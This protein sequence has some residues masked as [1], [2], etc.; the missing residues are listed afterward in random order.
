[1][2]EYA[3]KGYLVASKAISRSWLNRICVG[4]LFISLLVILLYISI[5]LAPIKHSL[6]L[7]HNIPDPIGIYAVI[8][9]IVSCVLRFW[10]PKDRE[11]IIG[12]TLYLLV[13][14]LALAINIASAEPIS[15]LI[16]I[17]LLVASFAGFFGSSMAITSSALL[18]I[19]IGFMWINNQ[20]T[21]PQAIQL[22]ILGISP[23]ILGLI[24]WH[25]DKTE[26]K[27]EDT[28]K[29]IVN[30]LGTTKSK[31]DIVISNIDD[32]VL[33]ISQ[34]GI[35]ELINPAA[36]KLLGW[37]QKDA[38]NL[39]WKSVLKIITSDG[40]DVADVDNPIAQALDIKTPVH[41]DRFQL[42]TA[43]EKRLLISLVC[44]PVGGQ[45]GGGIIAVFRDIT[46]EKAEEREQAEF[47]S[48]ASH[49][50]RTPVASIEGYLGLALNPATATIDEKARDFINKAHESA[51]H[52]GRLFQ[53]LLDISKADDGR[54]NSQPEVLDVTAFVGDIFE[55]LTHK[56]KEKNLRYIFKPNPDAEKSE[57]RY[58]GPI[59]YANVDPDHFRE[60]TANL[61]ENAIKYTL[62]GDVVVDVT[63]DEK[64]VTVSIQDSGIGIP[65]EDIPHL[66]QK[67]YRVDNS[68]TREIGGTGLGLYLSRKLAESMSGYLRVESEYK[69]GS[70]FFLDVPRI[71]HEEAMKKLS[72]ATEKLPEIQTDTRPAL[73]F[74]NR[75]DDAISF[76][77]EELPSMPQ[78]RINTQLSVA[79][80]PQ[81]E[82]VQ[83]PQQQLPLATDYT[84]PRPPQMATIYQ[85][86][87][88]QQAPVQQQP[89]PIQPQQQQPTIDQ[90]HQIAEQSGFRRPARPNP[91][92]SD[93]ER[94]VHYRQ[95]QSAQGRH[96]A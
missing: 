75:S 14:V 40:K 85:Q 32:G 70:T 3:K 65:A 34:D 78:P 86:M 37:S 35:I 26:E 56:A 87:P 50:M 95:Q 16:S 28:Y 80:Q 67:F 27:T 47:I 20:T 36:Q 55:G 60:V 53:D 58:I 64:N 68:D 11:T 30:N 63:G 23:I 62:S 89:A 12:Q 29:E 44:T 45:G 77:N 31:S 43:S 38:T 94:H 66:F 33:A 22:F 7:A 10:S 81:T 91:S 49:E 42:L 48:T 41:S 25:S 90:L 46:K 19:S 96:L 82:Q 5:N 8:L 88:A 17:W 2:K 74:D 59:Y 93:I 13:V 51:Q 24:L 76:V 71:S 15:L 54:L 73:G 57:E 6:F 21:P 61:I 52:L 69:K 79:P 84:I 9:A 4:A 83:I 39:S 1:M 72:E 92:L 18:A